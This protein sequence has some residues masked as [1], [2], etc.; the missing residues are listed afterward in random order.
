MFMRR[1]RRYSPLGRQ[2]I[3]VFFENACLLSGDPARQ[4]P[5]GPA[6]QGG[7][8]VSEALFSPRLRLRA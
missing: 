1:L 6:E 5:C 8:S 2:K 7:R 3:F 4:V